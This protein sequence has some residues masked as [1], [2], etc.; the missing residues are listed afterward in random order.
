MLESKTAQA[1]LKMEVDQVRPSVQAEQVALQGTEN[2]IVQEHE[3]FYSENSSSD[4]I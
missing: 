3:D 2:N 1:E 4:Q